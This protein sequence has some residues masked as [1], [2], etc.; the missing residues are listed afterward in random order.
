MIKVVT[1]GFFNPLHIGHLNLLRESKKLGTHLCV[2]VNT[3]H[4]VGLKGSKIFMDQWE[5]MEIIKAIKYVDQVVL[6]ADTDMTVNETLKLL[7]PDVFAK[8]GDSV[9]ENTP[10]VKLCEQLAIKVVFGV[11]GDK[12]QSSRWLKN[13]K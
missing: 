3:D 9:P 4:Q 8:G 2:I 5:R 11:G 6:C 12:V 7:N 1:S 13:E 10:E